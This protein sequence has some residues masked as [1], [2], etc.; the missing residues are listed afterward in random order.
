M[1]GFLVGTVMATVPVS[2][3]YRWWYLR[4]RDLSVFGNLSSTTS[5]SEL[6]Q[7]LALSIVVAL[8]FTCVGLSLGLVFRR[9][10]APAL[11]FVVWNTMVPMLGAWDP[12]NLW[13]LIGH[14]V[15][16]LEGVFVLSPSIETS[17]AGAV[18]ALSVIVLSGLVVGHAVSQR[19]SRFGT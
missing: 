14:R 12:R 10:L 15:F 19:A 8:F 1:L 2:M 13:S 7:T 11:V 18:A 3:L 5:L 9:A 6:A 4:D 16:R 17:L